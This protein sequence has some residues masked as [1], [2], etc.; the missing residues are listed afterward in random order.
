MIDEFNGR[1]T[2]WARFSD[3]RTMRFRLARS[4]TSSSLLVVDGSV[5]LID[6]ALGGPHENVPVRSTVF[7]MLN[8][9][10]ADAFRPDNTVTR[11]MGFASRWGCQLYEAVNIEPFRSTDP[12][13]L[14]TWTDSDRN[15]EENLQHILSACRHATIVIAS[16]GVHG[17][18]RGRG[19]QVRTFL[20]DHGIR[21]HHLG[22]TKDGH[23]K[24]PLYLKADTEPTEWR[25]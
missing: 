1:L 10:K 11:G 12:K 17:E 14:Y 7:C 4:L 16:W 2:G 3:C 13:G 8:P 9:S 19:R 25:P 22:L 21:L 18:H 15:H 20:A 23:P 5:V 6:H 24:H